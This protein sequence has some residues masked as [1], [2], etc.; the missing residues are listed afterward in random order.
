MI[1]DIIII[2]LFLLVIFIGYK[3]GFL[4]TLLKLA[5]A[6]SGIIIALCLTQPVTNL[7]VEQGWNDSIETKI[8]E[9][10]V[11]SEAFAAYVDGGQGVEGLNN[12]LKEVGVPAFM[13]EFVAERIAEGINPEEI[14]VSISESVGYVITLVVVFVALLILSA[15]L[16]AVL[17]L[18]I[19]SARKT[20]GI[21]RLVDGVLGVAFYGLIFVV[22]LYVVFFV[23][24]LIMKNAPVDSSLV[25]F[26]TEQLHLEDD[27]FGLAKYFYENNIITKFFELIF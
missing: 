4:S 6:I 17:K 18:F 23:L 2:L 5:S 25:V 7:A 20:T 14:A 21:I 24:S 12:L 16:F 13:S 22:V 27:K 9:N 3:T 26:M 1:L 11:S 19:K 15:L 10:I 8:Y